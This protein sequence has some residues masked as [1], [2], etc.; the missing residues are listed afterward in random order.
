MPRSPLR[1]LS[2]PPSHSFQFSN[3]LILFSFPPYLLDISWKAKRLPAMDI[4]VAEIAYDVDGVQMVGLLAKPAGAGSLPGALVAHEAA[5]MSAHSKEVAK[6]LARLGIVALA[7]DYQGYGAAKTDL[8]E[9]YQQL[10]D[11]TADPTPIVRRSEAA[12]H[13]LLQQ[14][15]VDPTRIAAL[16]YCFGGTAILELARTGVSLAA[17]IGFHPGLAKTRPAESARINAPVLMFL[18]GL[19][20]ITPAEQRRAFEDEMNAAGVDWRSMIF[21]RAGHSF[22]NPEADALNIPHVNYDA[23]ADS[24]SWQVALSFL[25]EMGVLQDG[26]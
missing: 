24:N 14:E 21:G 10:A 22:T 2:T 23:T 18:G 3:E 1:N 8:A 26:E 6:R 4:E 11:W 19:D 15:G 13:Q 7:Y 5:G 20:E 25:R 17:L 12:L 9:V 16:G